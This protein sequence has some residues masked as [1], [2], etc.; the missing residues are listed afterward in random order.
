MNF[1]AGSLSAFGYQLVAA[2]T[3]SAVNGALKHY[4]SKS[5]VVKKIYILNDGE[6]HY[7]EVEFGKD[8]SDIPDTYPDNIKKLAQESGRL[9]SELDSLNLFS[10]N[11]ASDAVSK[12]YDELYLNY[13]IYAEEGLPQ[14][15][16]AEDIGAFYVVEFLPTTDVNNSYI[17]YNLC[18]KNITILDIKENHRKLVLNKVSQPLVGGSGSA[19]K[20]QYQFNIGFKDGDYKKLP[21]KLQ[22]HIDAISGNNSDIFTISNL[23][24]ILNSRAMTITPDISG[25]S[26]EAND[27][28]RRIFVRYYFDLLEQNNQTVF[29]RVLTP[30]SNTSNY[31]FVPQKFT[32]TVDNPG[33]GKNGYDPV[34][35]TLN[36][37]VMCNNSNLPYLQP[38]GWTWVEPSQYQYISGIMEI[39]RDLLFSLIC[40]CFRV[41][42]LKEL[43]V[44]VGT[45]IDSGV[46]KLTYIISKTIDTNYDTSLF[47]IN[48]E[49]S[50]YV[51]SYESKD[52]TDTHTIYVPPFFAA[53]GSLAAEYTLSCKASAGR[54]AVEGVY[55]PCII[56]DT[57]VVGW[58]DVV[59][60]GGHSKGTVFDKDIVF[61]LGIAVDEYGRVSYKKS[62]SVN[63][64]PLT[65]NENGW[66]KFASFGEISKTVDQFK[67]FLNGEIEKCSNSAQFAFLES[68]Q[69][70]MA[71]VMPGNTTFTYK[72]EN[73]T[74][75]SDFYTEIS[76]VQD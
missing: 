58:L 63:S 33:F 59:Y 2:V 66:S 70:Q 21:P 3:H 6:D 75:G 52:S 73:F 16:T 74:A 26:D 68:F 46:S 67:G 35:T 19:W 36:Y 30:K 22:A 18:F 10:D 55:Y 37:I 27:Y 69:T 1:K 24:M 31:L 28:V 64:N 76:Y 7:F 61:N 5:T 4:L 44:I 13:A 39:S 57:H 12:A 14:C 32:L 45:S 48:E 60:D 71:W 34:L 72:N 62:V 17:L 43:R 65:M 23:I 51:Y 41:E 9:F 38:F 47:H 25:L 40:E 50:A 15:F 11:P 29:G 42:I 54:V 53:S 20:F 49:K 56:F 8:C